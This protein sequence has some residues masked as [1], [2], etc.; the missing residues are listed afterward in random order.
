M[1]FPKAYLADKQQTSGQANP[2]VQRVQIWNRWGVVIVTV[3]NCYCCD[4]YEKQGEQKYSCMEQFQFWL[5][6]VPLGAVNQDSFNK[7]IIYV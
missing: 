6:Y 1:L 7:Q 5:P 2:T 3:E 4:Q